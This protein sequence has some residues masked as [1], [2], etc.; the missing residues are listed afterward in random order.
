MG[1]SL[2]DRCIQSVQCPLVKCPKL[3]GPTV[4]GRQRK[5]LA[6]QCL[7]GV[8]RAEPVVSSHMP[9]DE[10]ER[11]VRIITGSQQLG[12]PLNGKRDAVTV[13]L[14]FAD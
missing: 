9:G 4:F 13:I 3:V 11:L 7:R 1:H 10:I 2:F 14:A 12:G 5:E 8:R 6:R